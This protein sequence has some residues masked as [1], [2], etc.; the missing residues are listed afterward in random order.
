MTAATSSVAFDVR[1]NG[2]SVGTVTFPAGSTGR[3]LATFST[4]GGAVVNFVAGDELSV[5]AG[6]TPDITFQG[7]SFSLEGLR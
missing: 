7:F 5:V 3:N 2:T 1:K 6:V 4:V